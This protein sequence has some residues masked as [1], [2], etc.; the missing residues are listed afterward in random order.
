[1]N[2]E[3][4]RK[5]AAECAECFEEDDDTTVIAE[6]YHP[7][8]NWRITLVT[9]NVRTAF[10]EIRTVDYIVNFHRAHL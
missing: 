10:H 8:R 4:A 7:G 9:G 1:M 3:Q 2:E 5:L 6:Y